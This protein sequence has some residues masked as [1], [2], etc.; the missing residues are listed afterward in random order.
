MKAKS[1][2]MLVVG[3][4]LMVGGLAHAAVGVLD[5]GSVVGQVTNVNVKGNTGDTFDGNTYTLDMTDFASSQINW[6]DV[7]N[8]E[9]QTAGINWTDVKNMEI[10]TA[11]INWQDVKNAEIQTAGINW[12]SVT[13]EALQGATDV[14]WATVTGL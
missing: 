9:I 4:C 11:G 14:N 7:K 3:L 1:L 5:D 6:T 10:Q 13:T 8:M 12:A 2:F